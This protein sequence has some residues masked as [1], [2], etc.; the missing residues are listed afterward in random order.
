MIAILGIVLRGTYR[1]SEKGNQAMDIGV[2]DAMVGDN[3][4][5]GGGSRL[6]YADSSRG[7][8]H[9]RSRNVKHRTMNQEESI[10]SVMGRRTQ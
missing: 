1:G 5:N 7:G 6:V 4:D 3:D 8:S 2:D 10:S 9:A